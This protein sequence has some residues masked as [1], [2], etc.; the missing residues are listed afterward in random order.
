[1]RAGVDRAGFGEGQ[2]LGAEVV[3]GAGDI[4]ADRVGVFWRAG[5]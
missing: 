1:M 3:G 2:V 5:R 4:Q